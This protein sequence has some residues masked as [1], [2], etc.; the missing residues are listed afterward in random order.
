MLFMIITSDTIV[1]ISSMANDSCQRFDSCYFLMMS[2]CTPPVFSVL[3]LPN[4]LNEE[5]LCPVSSA[6]YKCD[7]SLFQHFHCGLPCL[8][9]PRV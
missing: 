9:C 4:R 2:S 1:G 8:D 6:L 5:H 7:M 3:L